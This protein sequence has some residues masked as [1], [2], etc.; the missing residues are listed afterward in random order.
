MKK[1]LEKSLLLF[2][3][4]F[5]LI[6]STNIFAAPLAKS[7]R[8]FQLKVY[9]YTSSEQE[10]LIDKYLQNQFLPALHASGLSN[11]G[12]FKAIANDTATDKKMYVF[13][14]FESL[15]QWEKYSLKADKNLE[16]S[17]EYVTATG[18]KPAFNRIENIFLRAFELMPKIVPSK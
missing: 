13:V 11:I 3:F 7:S 9:H 16:G 1:L 15:K 17:D 2:A 12:V 10:A 4:I 8:Y 6:F 5:T 18:D 14:P